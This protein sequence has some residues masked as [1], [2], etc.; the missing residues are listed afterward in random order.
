MHVELLNKLSRDGKAVEKTSQT[1]EPRY[2]RISKD[3]YYMALAQTVSLRSTCIRRQYGA[4]IV[5]SGDHILSTGYNGAARN[6][7][8]CLNVG[9]ERERLNVPKGERYELCVSVHAEANAII[10]AARGGVSING[11]TLYVNGT[12]C[13]MCWRLIKNAGIDEVVFVEDNPESGDFGNVM[14]VR[15]QDATLAHTY[16]VSREEC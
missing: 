3:E 13:K 8:H 10:Q 4:I 14:R 6:E 9:C 5:S 11:A 1:S 12:P 2:H 16:P 7:P 15:A